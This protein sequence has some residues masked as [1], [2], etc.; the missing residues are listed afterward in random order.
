[1]KKGFIK[2]LWLALGS[3]IMGVGVSLFVSPTGIVPGGVTG[4]AIILNRFVEVGVGRIILLINLPLL[5]A[6][7]KKFG[8]HFFFLTLTALLMSSVAID[9]IAAFPPA[10]ND[11]IIASL[12]GGGLVGLGVGI[13]LRCNATTGGIDIVVRLVKEKMPHIK[14]GNVFL[15]TD[16][17]IALLSGA[18][19]NSLELSV[20]SFL[21]IGV[22]ARVMN[23][24]LYGMNEAKL[25][26]IISSKGERVV[27][28]LT[29]QLG[30][31]VSVL[32]AKG[33]YTGNNRAVLICAVRNQSYYKVKELVSRTDKNAFVIVAS[34]DSIYGEGFKAIDIKE[35]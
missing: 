4:V 32:N 29:E 3:V 16:G 25:F 5:A 9:V 21:S 33:G 7:L 14:T 35:I 10:T 17:V 27:K 12:A 24:V 6:S 30:A 15:I 19:L 22:S 20:Y 1:M 26:F 34:A 11:M 2:L 13:I 18:V 8:K 23:F 31:G 28:E